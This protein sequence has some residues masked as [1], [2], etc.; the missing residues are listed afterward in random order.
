MKVLHIWLNIHAYK[1]T[2]AVLP[3]E[4]STRK[5]LYRYKLMETL[6]EIKEIGTCIQM[7]EI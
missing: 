5:S 1:A 2:L 7:K 6:H 4:N 3:E